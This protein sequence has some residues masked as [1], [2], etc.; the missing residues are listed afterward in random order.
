MGGGACRAKTP[1][2]K[3]VHM[4][5]HMLIT[6]HDQYMTHRSLP[7]ATDATLTTLSNARMQSQRRVGTRWIVARWNL[8][9]DVRRGR[10]FAWRSAVDVR[11]TCG[12]GGTVTAGELRPSQVD[13][14]SCLSWGN[15]PHSTPTAFPA[16]QARRSACDVRDTYGWGGTAMAG[17]RRPSQVDNC[18]CLSW[19]N[20]PHSTP[21]DSESRHTKP[22]FFVVI[23]NCIRSRRLQVLRAYGCMRVL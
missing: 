23:E 1:P 18:S 2:K 4:G 5:G 22:C 12:W 21:T 16:T 8:T 6:I 17:E 15:P 7:D 9:N 19:G 3:H 14:R 11:D 20:P 10:L 13:N